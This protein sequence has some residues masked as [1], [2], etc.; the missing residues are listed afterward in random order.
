MHAS[1]FGE[2]EISAVPTTYLATYIYTHIYTY[3]PT[4]PPTYIHTCILPTTHIRI[5]LFQMFCE[6][7]RGG[8]VACFGGEIQ[9]HELV[10]KKV[11]GQFVE[12]FLSHTHIGSG[13]SRFC[14]V[15]MGSR[16]GFESIPKSVGVCKE[17]W[18]RQ[19]VGV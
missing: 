10:R 7:D 3:L 6:A 8:A 9:L 14:H 12:L 15:H 5:H 17:V 4:H 1:D 16:S 11:W 2:V 19:G 18:A 13:L